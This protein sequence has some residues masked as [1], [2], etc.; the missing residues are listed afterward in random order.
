MIILL[1]IREPPLTRNNEERVL[2]LMF[3][4]RRASYVRCLGYLLY[5]SRSGPHHNPGSYEYPG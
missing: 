3:A 1:N 4:D 2:A 5:R